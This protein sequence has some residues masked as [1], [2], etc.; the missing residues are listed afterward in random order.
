LS[1]PLYLLPIPL[2]NFCLLS[3]SFF[4]SRTLRD[5]HSF[6]TRRSSDLILS[7]MFSLANIYPCMNAAKVAIPTA[8]VR[9][10]QTISNAVGMATRSEEH[11]SELQSRF[12]LVCRLLLEKKK[13][14]TCKRRTNRALLN[15]HL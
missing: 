1:S 10:D 8:A 11:T 5:L 13:N 15:I 7:M 12:D 2:L 4:S 3:C 9:T 14:I 6:P